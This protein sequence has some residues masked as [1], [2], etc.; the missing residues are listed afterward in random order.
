MDHPKKNEGLLSNVLNIGNHCQNSL[1]HVLFAHVQ[2]KAEPPDYEDYG[3]E[4]RDC[5]KIKNTQNIHVV[6]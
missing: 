6:S 2:S 5:K 4:Y 3:T 1:S